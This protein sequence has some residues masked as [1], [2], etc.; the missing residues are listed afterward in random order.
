MIPVKINLE[1]NR[2]NFSKL[3]MKEQKSYEKT[4]YLYKH[5]GVNQTMIMD[6]KSQFL[7]SVDL[8]KRQGFVKSEVH[9]YEVTNLMRGIVKSS[10]IHTFTKEGSTVN[11]GT[12]LPSLAFDVFPGYSQH[13]IIE[14]TLHKKES[15]EPSGVLIDRPSFNVRGIKVNGRFQKLEKVKVTFIDGTTKLMRYKESLKEEG[16]V[17]INKK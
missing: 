3:L 12:D 8:Y 14:V 13:T 11:D 15:T 7:S 4:I 6:T 10:K 16:V 1:Q 17:E 5:W 9:N 2:I